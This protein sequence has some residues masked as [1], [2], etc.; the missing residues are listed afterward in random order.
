MLTFDACACINVT[1]NIVNNYFMWEIMGGTDMNLMNINIRNF[2]DKFDEINNESVEDLISRYTGALSQKEISEGFGVHETTVNGWWKNNKYPDYAKIIMGLIKSFEDLKR[3]HRE[4]TKKTNMTIVIKM[5][6]DFG[7]IELDD[8]DRTLEANIVAEGISNKTTAEKLAA[9]INAGKLLAELTPEMIHAFDSDFAGGLGFGEDYY[10]EN[11]TD[12]LY[13]SLLDLVNKGM[14]V[15][16]RQGTTKYFIEKAIEQGFPSG[17][18]ATRDI[19]NM[20]REH[21]TKDELTEL[22]PLMK[23]GE[24]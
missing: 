21:L 17:V 16:H 10:N 7:L 23:K 13:A 22:E 6:D 18:D 5:G 9:Q 3:S 4:L 1:L 2:A 19:F 8:K 12:E 11:K 14:D 15:N 20:L 24:S